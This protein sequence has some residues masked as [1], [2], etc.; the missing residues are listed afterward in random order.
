MKIKY[1]VNADKKLTIAKETDT[2]KCEVD[3]TDPFLIAAL[4]NSNANTLSYKK[5]ASMPHMSF[6]K[7]SEVDEYDEKTGKDVARDKLLIKHYSRNYE[8]LQMV[9][10]ALIDEL[11]YVNKLIVSS[12]DKIEAADCR[13]LSIEAGEDYAN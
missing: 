13:L 5:L 9:K 2:G 11:E 4:V 6:A 7:C 8:K 10:Q 1:I 12:T 3:G